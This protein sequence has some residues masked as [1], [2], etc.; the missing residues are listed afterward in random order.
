[1]NE[2]YFKR[3]NE[4][5]IEYE[6]R[7]VDIKK[8]EKPDDLD[9]EDIK[10]LTGYKGNKDSLRKA[11]DSEYGGYAIHKYYQNKEIDKT[12]KN[13]LQEITDLIGELD[14]KKIEVRNKTN[15]LNRIKRNFVKSIEISNDLKECILESANEFPKLNYEPI[16]DQ[17]ENKLIVVLA[18]W[19]IGY[20]INGYKGNYYNYDIAQLRLSKLLAEIDKICNKYNIQTVVIANV[21]DIIENVYM[22]QN[23]A[24]E[25]EF[26]LSQQIAKASKLLYSFATKISKTKNVEVY[27][28]GGNHSR[29]STKDANIE[30]DNANVI[31][32]ENLITYVEIANNNRITIGEVD[33]KDDT[34]T[35]KVNNINVKILHGDNRVGDSKKLFDAESSMD[36]VKYDLILRGHYHNFSMSSQNNGG[37]VV[38]SGCL[39]GYNPYSVKKMSCNTNAS[40]TL[41]VVG[42]DEIESIKP[43]NLQI[44]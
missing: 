31:I 10:T 36:N 24:Y 14:V 30:G 5:D 21:G 22:R 20:V 16:I 27:S 37:Y 12:P 35:F 4:N 42:N 26:N 17:S 9:W 19:H 40:Q 3:N 13:K 25:C 33:Y 15:Q 23:Q 1:M 18:D 28:V 38:T 2:R 6:L 39:F 29:L 32:N 44:N 11:N 41:I 7:L 8:T 34:A 43:I